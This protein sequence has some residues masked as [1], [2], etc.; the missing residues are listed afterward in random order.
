M[1]QEAINTIM[2]GDILLGIFQIIMSVVVTIVNLILYPFSLLIEQ[3]IPDLDQA[4][5]S[6][7]GYFNYAGTYMGWLLNALAIPAIVV[8]MVAS[9]YMF[10]FSTTFG[11]WLVKLMIKWKQAIWR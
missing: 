7:A 6:L 5:L 3:F 9:Y 2:N 10:S 1:W 8:T 4:L 11:A